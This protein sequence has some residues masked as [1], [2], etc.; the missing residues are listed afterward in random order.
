MC[1]CVNFAHLNVVERIRQHVNKSGGLWGCGASLKV[2]V[3]ELSVERCLSR[4]MKYVRVYACMRVYACVA[5]CICT[6][7]VCVWCLFLS[8][9]VPV[10]GRVCTYALAC[11]YVR[12]YLCG[13]VGSAVCIYMC[14]LLCV[15]SCSCPEREKSIL[16]VTTPRVPVNM[17]KSTAFSWNERASDWAFHKYMY[18]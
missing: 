18:P 11:I 8:L 3:N 1:V 2:W 15:Y 17:I 7:C 14:V 6:I 10:L 9:Y 5:V 4:K 12:M 16:S 13:C